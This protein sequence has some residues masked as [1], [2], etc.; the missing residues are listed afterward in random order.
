MSDRAFVGSIPEVY[1]RCLGP[2]LFEPYAV[3]LARRLA[4]GAPEVVLE[5][6]AGTG[7]VTAEVVRALPAARIVATDLNQAMLDIAAKK[8]DSPNVVWQTADAQEL[9]FPDGPFDG[10][11]CQFGV[12][13]LPDKAR[14]Y[15]EM[16]RVTR[17]GGT[18]LFNVWDRIATTPLA[19]AVEA[20]LARCFPDD[21]PQFFSRVPHG[22]HDA[23][24]IRAAVAAAGFD[25]VDV[26]AVVLPSR[27][28]SAREVATGFC[29]GTPMRHEITARR[30]DGLQAVTDAVAEA[31]ARQFGPGEVAADMRAYVVT[32]A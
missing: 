11:V 10:V 18:V 5:I 13:F 29:Q 12:M 7:I 31:I 16:R 2:L 8:L 26:E 6:A 20:E 23:P 19:A 27:G 17:A 30:P 4:A 9:P 21:P 1:D 32:A 28:P 25:S 14:A 15:R 3:D 22:Y 24:A